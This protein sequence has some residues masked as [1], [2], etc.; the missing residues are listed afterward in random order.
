MT[1]TSPAVSE[2][3]QLAYVTQRRTPKQC[4]TVQNLCGMTSNA[5]FVSVDNKTIHCTQDLAD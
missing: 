4:C 2:C 3:K 5:I 1:F